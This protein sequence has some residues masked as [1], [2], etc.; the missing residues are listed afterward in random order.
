M[1]SCLKNIVAS[2]LL[3]FA[4]SVYCKDNLPP[5]LTPVLHTFFLNSPPLRSNRAAKECRPHMQILPY[6]LIVVKP[7]AH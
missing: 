7:W 5:L 6:L 4:F 2:D 3:S 1:L